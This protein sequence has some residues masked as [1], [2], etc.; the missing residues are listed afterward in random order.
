MKLQLLCLLLLAA[1]CGS[2][3]ADDEFSG[4]SCA[5]DIAVALKGRHLS[6]APVEATQAAH[7]DLD[8]KDIGADELDW[9]SAIWWRICGTTYLAIADQKPV[10][11]DVLKLPSQPGTTL[12]F[13]G[14][15]KGG[16]KDKE[17]IAIV[18]DKAGATELPA[19]AAW[20]IDDAKQRFATVPAEG[21][22]CPRGDGIVDS[23]K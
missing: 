17:V 20:I 19:K 9:G 18:E 16:P 1:V 7:K 22:L 8:L 4:I 14:V 5:S 12:V 21:L 10:I 2:A 23:W 15:C 6:S 13:N 11:R 3:A